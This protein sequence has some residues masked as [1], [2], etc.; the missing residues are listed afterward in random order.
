MDKISQSPILAAMNRL[1]QYLEQ[2]EI[3]QVEFARRMGVAQPTVSGWLSGTALPSA[4]ML[5]A[6]TLKTGLT[7][8]E[9][10]DHSTPAKPPRSELRA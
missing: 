2:N 4:E 10:L 8:D 5:K 7:I 9:L 6:I 3:T 1:R